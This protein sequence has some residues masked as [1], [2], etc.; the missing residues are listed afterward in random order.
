MPGFPF[1]LPG[2]RG[3]VDP[4][5]TQTSSLGLAVSVIKWLFPAGEA[6]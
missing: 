6:W 5:S 3:N 4:Q 2:N 1:V